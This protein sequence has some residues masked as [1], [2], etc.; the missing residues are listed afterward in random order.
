DYD[1]GDGEQD[2]KKSGWFT[3]NSGG[4]THPVGQKAPNRWNLHDMHGNV[5]EWCQ[6]LY[7][8]AA[9]ATRSD[10]VRSQQAPPVWRVL[11]GGRTPCPAWACAALAVAPG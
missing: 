1:S 8:P 7:S 2:L 10:P 5:W 9:P 11:R 3:G 6:D 4:K